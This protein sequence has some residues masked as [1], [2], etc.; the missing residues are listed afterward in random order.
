MTKT[1]TCIPI[2]TEENWP[3]KEDWKNPGEGDFQIFEVISTYNYRIAK[4]TSFNQKL[5]PSLAKI[6]ISD[7]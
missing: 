7:S 5:E 2:N 1:S 4:Y 3:H 6:K